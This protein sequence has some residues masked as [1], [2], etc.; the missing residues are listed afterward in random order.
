MRL[1]TSCK[2]T[3]VPRSFPTQKSGS[4]EMN[5]SQQSDNSRNTYAQEHDNACISY[6]MVATATRQIL[7]L[8]DVK[9]QGL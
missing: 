2:H 3:V 7:V 4:S 8:C 6:Y 5:M 1:I 9:A